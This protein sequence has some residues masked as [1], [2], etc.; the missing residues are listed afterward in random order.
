MR[1][2]VSF[3]T[4][5]LVAALM[6]P[7][8]IPHTQLATHLRAITGPLGD[9]TDELVSLGQALWHTYSGELERLIS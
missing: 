2:S 8:A 9:E 1:L 6:L 7:V 3:L 5:A 4:A